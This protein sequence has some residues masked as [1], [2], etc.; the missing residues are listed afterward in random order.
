M[1]ANRYAV[2]WVFRNIGSNIIDIVLG[3][4]DYTQA[5]AGASMLPDLPGCIS[6]FAVLCGRIIVQKSSD[7][8]YAIENV[9]DTAFAQAS[10]TTHNDLGGLQGGT[11]GEYYHVTA[12]EKTVIANTSGT[13]TGDQTITLTGDVTGAGQGSFAATIANKAVSLA[14]MADLAASSIIGNNTLAS[15]T[16][17]ALTATQVRTLINV[18]DGANNYVHPNHSG[19]VTSVAD[20]ATTIANGA[21]SLAKMA[22]LAANSIIG[23][24]TG[25]A[26]VP[27]AL[28]VAEVQTMLSVLSNPMTTL[29]DI[30]Y[31]GASGLATRLAGNTSA[32]RKFLAQTGDGANSAAPE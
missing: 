24:N 10:I 4:G 7:T 17:I 18:A 27:K 23:N 25:G 6:N 14:K 5:Q 22:N 20:G 21:V 13:N 2:N 32:T 31:G 16:P 30:I 11:P 9:R 15:A 8:A 29:G 26:A 3:E 1:T 19:D 28:T 12:A